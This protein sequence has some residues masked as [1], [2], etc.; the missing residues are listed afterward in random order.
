VAHVC[1]SRYSGV[2]DREGESSRPT[3]AKANEIPSQPEAS[4]MVHTCNPSYVGVFTE[5][6]TAEHRCCGY[7]SLSRATQG[8]YLG[9]DCV[10]STSDLFPPACHSS[11][12]VLFLLLKHRE[13]NLVKASVHMCSLC[14]QSIPQ[15]AADLGPPH[16]AGQMS[17]LQKDGC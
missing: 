17:S 13:L 7:E 5:P 1:N 3:W 8:K 6:E 16:N 12:P 15:I 10:F 4:M 9:L 2:G 14:L 11:H